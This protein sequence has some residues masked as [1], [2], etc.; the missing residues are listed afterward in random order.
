MNKVFTGIL[1]A[2]L[3]LAMSVSL[4]AAGTSRRKN[5]GY[6]LEGDVNRDCEVD[7]LDLVTV[8]NA[9]GSERGD[10]TYRGFLDLNKDGKIDLLD[11]E[12][13]KENYGKTCGD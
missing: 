11:M 1:V 5:Y 9:Y 12:I 10:G 4:V 8:A 3:A 2:V 13:V 7:I 6:R